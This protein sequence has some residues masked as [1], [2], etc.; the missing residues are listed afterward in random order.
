MSVQDGTGLRRFRWSRNNMT[1]HQTCG[2]LD[3]FYMSSSTTPRK[4][5]KIPSVCCSQESLASLYLHASQVD[6]I[7]VTKSN[8]MIK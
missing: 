6:L 4:I 5:S 8:S 1:L 7:P 2:A 3:A